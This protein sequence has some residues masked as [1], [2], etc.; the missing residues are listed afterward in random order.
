MRLLKKTDTILDEAR[1]S[2]NRAWLKMAK[3]MPIELSKNSL[4]LIKN[5]FMNAYYDGRLDQLKAQK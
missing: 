1:D 5:T 4:S 3:T 2:A